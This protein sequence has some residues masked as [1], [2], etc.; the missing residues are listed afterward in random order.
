M[1]SKPFS[2]RGAAVWLLDTR[3]PR[4]EASSRTR[5]K[6]ALPVWLASSAVG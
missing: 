2:S 5:C 6:A 1:R 4:V 3:R